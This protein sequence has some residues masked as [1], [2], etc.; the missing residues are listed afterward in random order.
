[1]S[2]FKD[3]FKKKAFIGFVTAGDPDL[4][5]TEQFIYK[6]IE[7]GTALIE[8]GIPFSDPIAEGKTIFNADM[9][10]IASG[11]TTDKIF[12]GALD[13]YLVLLFFIIAI[14]MWSTITQ[15]CRE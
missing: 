6:M 11:T 14:P 2:N 12:Y 1:V 13:T 9:R 15:Y 5:S 10:A 3:V 7:A 8:I 4:E